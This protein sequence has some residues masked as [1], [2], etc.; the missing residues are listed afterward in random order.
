MNI[1]QVAFNEKLKDIGK[2][3]VKLL[4]VKWFDGTR[5]ELKGY[6]TQ[7]LLKLRYKGYRIATPPNTVAYAGIYLIG[8]ALKWFK[9][10]LIEYQTNRLTTTNLEMKYIFINWENFK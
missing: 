4:E 2:A 5:M 3:K 8:R 10:Y 7:I 6:L 1:G 9:S